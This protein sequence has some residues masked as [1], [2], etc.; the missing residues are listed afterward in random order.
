MKKLFAYIIVIIATIC[1]SILLFACSEEKPT[2]TASYTSA[3]GGYVY[4]INEQGHQEKSAWFEVNSGD[5]IKEITACPNK[6]FAFEKWSDGVTTATRQDKNVTADIRVQAIFVRVECYITYRATV[7]D[8]YIDG[9]TSQSVAPNTD[10]EQVT[11]VPNKGYVFVKWSDGVTTATRQDK[12]VTSNIEV[13]AIFR[14]EEYTVKY[15]VSGHGSIDGETEQKVSYQNDSATVTAVPDKGYKFVQWSDGL[16]EATRKETEV[17]ESMQVTAKFEPIAR[18]Y[19]LNYRKTLDSEITKQKMT[20][21]YDAL[22]GVKLPVPEKEHFIF[23]GWYYGEQKIA[24]EN[25]N[26]LIDDDFVIDEVI[27]DKLGRKQDIRAKWTAEETFP[28]KILIVYV[29]KIQ[30]RLY[31]RYGIYH[32]IDFRMTELQRRFCEEST[33]LLER[34]MNEMCDGL[35]DFRIDEYYTTQTITN[36]HLRQSNIEVSPMHTTLFPSAIPEIQEMMSGYDTVVSVFGFCGDDPTSDEAYLF[37]DDSGGA[38]FGECNVF[39]DPFIFGTILDVYKLTDILDGQ[40][41]KFWM[42]GIETF[43]HEI[44][45][46]IEMRIKSYSYHDAAI[47]AHVIYGIGT[48]DADRLYYLCGIEKDDKLV[49]IPYEFWKGDVA[50]VV[51]E[52]NRD[53][54]GGMGYVIFADEGSFFGGDYSRQEVVYGWDALAVEAEPYKGYRFVRWSDG[55]TTAKR[56][57]RNI[58]ADFTVTAIFEPIVY[59]IKIVASEGGSLQVAGAEDVKNIITIQVKMYERTDYV[60]AVAHDGYRFVGW[61]DGTTNNPWSKFINLSDLNIFDESNT[62]ILTAV[63]EKIE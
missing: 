53:E 3:D 48:L 28:F 23:G 26:L 58:T 40:G 34:T 13:S 11:A 56:K 5:D 59:T 31:D 4:Y 62:Y 49:G 36:E 52:V 10:A 45:H 8:G 25:G 55:V 41:K 39:L 33:K 6:G 60:N 30:A 7:I 46:T 43:S 15:I 1:S 63:F 61:S 27:Q 29:T 16:T 57:D 24:D 21:T 19:E 35:V 50:N 2:Y 9:K 47:D 32:D 17:S 38:N 14:K 22:D 18:E 20:L 42:E 44:A 12:N 51:Y 54:H 37:Q